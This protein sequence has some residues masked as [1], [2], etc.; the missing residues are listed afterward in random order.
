MFPSPINKSK[1]IQTAKTLL[2]TTSNFQKAEIYLHLTL[3]SFPDKPDQTDSIN[4]ITTYSLLSFINYKR[5]PQSISTSLW[6]LS[7]L[8]SISITHI[9]DNQTLI[10]YIKAFTWCSL[11]IREKH[12][13]ESLYYITYAMNTV[14]SHN[15]KLK[16]DYKNSIDNVYKECLIKNDKHVQRYL[17]LNEQYDV[18]KQIVNEVRNNNNNIKKDSEG[19]WVINRKWFQQVEMYVNMKQNLNLERC[20][21][22]MFND[23]EIYVIN[24]ESLITHLNS[25][26]NNDNDESPTVMLNPNEIENTMIISNDIYL[27]IKNV[28][29]ILF[30]LQSSIL[31]H[32]DEFKQVQLLILDNTLLNTHPEQCLLTHTY[33]NKYTTYH[34]LYTS[35]FPSNNSSHKLYTC[36][37]NNNELLFTLLFLYYYNIPTTI[38][39]PSNELEPVL[40][41]QKEYPMNNKVIIIHHTSSSANH[42]VLNIQHRINNNNNK[43]CCI[44]NNNNNNKSHYNCKT[45]SFMSYLHLTYCNEHCKHKDTSHKQ[46]HHHLRPFIRKQYTTN[47]LITKLSSHN[48]NIK[49]LINTG[50]TC[51]INSILQSLAHTPHFLTYFLYRKYLNDINTTHSDKSQLA[52]QLHD[53]FHSMWLSSTNNYNNAIS[54]LQFIYTFNSLCKNFVMNEQHDAS[55]FLTY[56]LDLL[57]ECLN[58]IEYK[59]Y[60]EINE[61]SYNQCITAFKQRDD[62][63]ITDLFQGMFQSSITCNTCKTTRYIYEQF[64]TLSLPIIPTNHALC[65]YVYNTIS[66][67]LKQHTINITSLNTVTPSFLITAVNA[68]NNTLSDYDI[69]LIYP[70][71][72]IHSVITPATYD[73]VRLCDIITALPAL[74]IVLYERQ[75]NAENIYITPVSHAIEYKLLF[76]PY[77]KLHVHS[78]PYAVSV[79]N[80]NMTIQHLYEYMY[81][82]VN[83]SNIRLWMWN[84]LKKEECDYCGC[85]NCE[86]CD[87]LQVFQWEDKV[88][89]LMRKRSCSNEAVI[90]ACEVSC[91]SVNFGKVEGTACTRG[92]KDNSDATIDLEDCLKE[93]LKE[94]VLDGENMWYCSN[95]N[96]KRSAVKQMSICKLPMYLVIQLKRFGS[97]GNGE[98]DG[99]HIENMLQI[100]DMLDNSSNS[101]SSGSGSGNNMKAGSKKKGRKKHKKK[102]NASSSSSTTTTASS[103]MNNNELL[104]DEL[105]Q[106]TSSMYSTPHSQK[107][108][109]SISFP[110]T[111]LNI[112]Q[113][114]H[115]ITSNTT[116]PPSSSSNST[117][118]LYSIINHY[119]NLSNGHY[120]STNLHFPSNTWYNYDD[121]TVSP[122]PL[123]SSPYSSST[124][125]LLFYKQCP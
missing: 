21:D 37:Y 49:G 90:M 81:K 29:G 99:N 104:L 13:L 75:C 57:H 79:V 114:I 78:F 85:L 2:N 115:T 121:S 112:S 26:T 5:C 105:L 44:C 56:L 87:M 65:F 52:E 116:N 46:L 124:A 84:Y 77:N 97:E 42:N 30:P 24:N 10:S 82:Q 94:E 3:L 98:Y 66:H 91:S 123:S 7:K 95:C 53:V 39:I 76:I 9:K 25:V 119:G 28:F 68:H 34:N 125:Y 122:H 6:L 100:Q 73:D 70:D 64:T 89:R 113:Y 50:N 17:K 61:S 69:V 33:I 1:L 40:H 117:Y 38:N 67:S 36:N 45:F 31:Q 88:E 23:N 47:N 54:P 19:C 86:M 108:N 15:I 102:N 41:E 118:N 59:P 48:T 103:A 58:R 63:I 14:K 72:T 111:N 92:V 35:L 107:N 11:I 8:K 101:G 18:I 55:E 71:N 20:S 43:C 96:E 93:F 22:D 32:K 80:K 110:I 12:P 4:L 62:S 120:T 51:Y 83:D 106:S 16:D 60:I 109:T 74:K 27:K